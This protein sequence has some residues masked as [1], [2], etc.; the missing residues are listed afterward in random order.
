MHEIPE[1]NAKELLW[2]FVSVA[3]RSTVCV[4]VL[5]Y[6]WFHVLLVFAS[7]VCQPPMKLRVSRP[8]IL[9]VHPPGTSQPHHELSIRRGLGSDAVRAIVPGSRHITV[10]VTAAYAIICLGVA[11]ALVPLYP[12]AA[13]W[14]FTLIVCIL[15][16]ALIALGFVAAKVRLAWE[17]HDA[18]RRA[19]ALFD[20]FRPNILV[21][22]N[23]GA[24]VVLRM[25]I[26]M[27]PVIFL[28]PAQDRYAKSMFRRPVTQ[29]TLERFPYTLVCHGAADAL[30]PFEDTIRLCHT[31][32]DERCHL[33]SLDSSDP[34]LSGVISDE[35][36][37]DIVLFTFHEGWI[38]ALTMDRPP[39][40]PK[41]TLDVTLISLPDLLSFC[42]IALHRVQ[43]R[44]GVL[45]RR[46]LTTF[47]EDIL[48]SWME[49]EAPPTESQTV[50][51]ERQRLSVSKT[52]PVP[53]HPEELRQAR[54]R[55][56]EIPKSGEQ[57]RL[58][59]EPVEEEEHE[60]VSVAP[61]VVIASDTEAS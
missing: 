41:M 37:R 8:R 51:E 11:A 61:E 59:T 54:K 33:I 38:S 39:P 42:T 34:V 20:T 55:R 27:V 50:R 35:E 36:M 3:R 31:V 56:T 40:L 53:T 22:S 24:V 15:A 18:A 13:L 2:A 52:V 29:F 19:E 48:A 23:I 17:V 9:F 57:E 60:T 30:V 25:K 6:F 58:L 26:P 16:G 14:S 49:E 46:P 43:T 5:D 28:T 7:D 45:P 10:T 12:V 1:H 21:T 32:P 44:E 4:S 47:G